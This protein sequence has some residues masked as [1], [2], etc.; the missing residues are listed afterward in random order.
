MNLLDEKALEMY[1][2]GK[3]LTSI[4]KE[5]H[6][7]RG[8]LAKR[9]KAAGLEIVQNNK[10]YHAD[11]LFFNDIDNEEKAY[12]LGFLMADGHLHSAEKNDYRIE[13]G[14]GAVD[15]DHLQKFLDSLKSSYPIEK[16]IVKLEGK[17]HETY[18]TM[19]YSKQLHQALSR[20]GCVEG[21]T[22]NM[23]MPEIRSDLYRH[24]VRGY[25][26]GDGCMSRSNKSSRTL[27][28]RISSGCPEFLYELSELL[29]KDAGVQL[30]FN[31]A[32]TCYELYRNHQAVIKLFLDYIYKDS[33][34]FLQRKYDAY[35]T[36]ISVPSRD[37]VT[38]VSGL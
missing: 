11:D 16:R 24:Y 32:H 15:K 25:F 27:Q 12:W 5:L 4:G 13:L 1:K 22:F 31:R 19:V 38:E 28:I 30:T 10:Q 18:R 9:L 29:E 8:C 34:V 23:K 37:K 7:D 20:L 14:L 35:C 21:K 3:S 17:K 6:M 26:D 36:Y 2:Q 33:S